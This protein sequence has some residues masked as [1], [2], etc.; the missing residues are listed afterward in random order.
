MSFSGRFTIA[1]RDNIQ[2]NYFRMKRKLAGL[3]AMTFVVAALLVAL[4]RYRQDVS[5]ADALIGA[6]A[7]GAAGCALMIGFSLVSVVVRVNRLYQ[8]GK[9]SDFTVQYVVDRT[10]VH[11][12]SERG[13]TDFDWKQ[14]LYLRETVHAY[15][16]IAEKGRAVVIPKSQIATDGERNALRAL[17]VK[18]IPAR[19]SVPAK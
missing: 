13:D 6:L 11:A 12:K 4:V 14:I 10:G 9:M 3:A 7:A 2:Y 19:R 16:L 18:Y 15:Y 1:K 17:F 5:M 8:Q